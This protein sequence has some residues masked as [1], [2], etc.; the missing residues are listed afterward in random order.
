MRR[1][2]FLARVSGLPAE[3]LGCLRRFRLPS[4]IGEANELHERLHVARSRFVD[5]LFELV[6]RVDRELRPL[7]LQAKRQAHNGRSIEALPADLR[8]PL[9]PEALQG[10]CLA[11]IELERQH[12][13]AEVRLIELYEEERLSEP[14]LARRHL[15]SPEILPALA[16][17]SRDLVAALGKDESL[18]PATRLRRLDKAAMRYLTR[19]SLKLSPF[20]SLTRVALGVT[21]A[22]EEGAGMHLAG[23]PWTAHSLLR[24]RRNLMDAAAALLIRHPEVQGR[25]AVH[26]NDTLCE[27]LPG[28][29]R[30]VRPMQLA[31]ARDTGALEWTQA[32]WVTARIDGPAPRAL[33]AELALGPRPLAELL[34]AL[35]VRLEVADAEEG[36]AELAAVVDELLAIGFLHLE[37]P[38]SSHA[39]HLEAS[40]CA[41]LR[42]LPESTGLVEVRAALERLL[43]AESAF[44]EAES[45]L[46][47][48]LELDGLVARV[49]EAAHRLHDGATVAGK[50]S[51]PSHNLY[52]DVFLAPSAAQGNN[53]TLE[54]AA[55]VRLPAR[56]EFEILAAA[57]ELWR[58]LNF[59][60]PRWNFLHSLAA[61]LRPLLPRGGNISFLDAFAASRGLLA[62]FIKWMQEPAST[63]FDPRALAAIADLESLRADFRTHLTKLLES[64][65]PVSVAAL[66]ALTARIPANYVPPIG[67]CAFVQ[68]ADGSG[69]LWVLNRLFEGT[70]R[71]ASRFTGTMPEAVR[72]AY[73][74]ELSDASELEMGGETVELLD[75]VYG[76]ETTINVHPPQT[77]QVLLIPG[78]QTDPGQSAVRLADLRLSLE[79]DLGLPVVR[80]PGGRRLLPCHL[81]AAESAYMPTLAKYLSFLGPSSNRSVSLPFEVGVASE[82]ECR[83]VTRLTVGNLVVRRRR[84]FIPTAKLPAPLASP[85]LRLA[86]T[87]AWFAARGLP[88]QFYLIER[89]RRGKGNRES[90]KPQYIDIMSPTLWEVFVECMSETWVVIEE[91]LPAHRDFPCDEL[92][93]RWGVELMLD[94]LLCGK[95]P[96]T[97][98]RGS[99]SALALKG[100][101]YEEGKVGHDRCVGDRAAER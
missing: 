67:P 99:I 72:Y 86:A 18:L 58:L 26:L 57:N 59:F 17:A 81:T 23:G 25:L 89:V 71:F 22:A 12:R 95:A 78:E 56:V 79:G 54:G 29:F 21:V 83:V 63:P 51:D 88:R 42:D 74:R 6:P 8:W 28:V 30:L 75:I 90:F 13:G 98:F 76:R 91:V 65:G 31:I 46:Q 55:L 34:A 40:M 9:L 33:L 41:Y 45:P 49:M 100:V 69:D 87:A 53:G 94:S 77:P 85:A 11:V 61:L 36:R 44:F 68:Q 52:H 27:T 93:R 43:A 84:W 50:K 62:D 35:A 60:H 4:V 5:R 1:G 7:L 3:A 101:E 66:S 96:A 97:G 39:V 20:S 10:D 16:L 15:R 47:A 32:A 92:G 38:W 2:I 64:H 14:A 82:G 48:A 73:C 37:P 70:G 80:G 24:A 19:I